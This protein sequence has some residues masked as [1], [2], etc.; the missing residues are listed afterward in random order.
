[1]LE[2]YA[3]F[4]VFKREYSVDRRKQESERIRIK[5]PD[6]VPVICERDPR[7]DIP[8]IDRKKYLVPGDLT[9]AQFTFVIRKRLKL[10]PERGMFLFVNG[11]C[12]QKSHL[13][14][15]LYEDAKDDDGFL[16]V[17]YAGENVFG[18]LYF[19]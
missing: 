18:A 7:S 3:M 15:A 12:P 11:A 17:S 1:M 5:Y 2:T 10:P 19:L 16:Y 9:V 13:M 6:R 4:Q 14:S 8:N